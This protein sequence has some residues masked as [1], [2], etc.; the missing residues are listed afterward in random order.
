MTTESAKS[1]P[2]QT[3][4]LIVGDTKIE[5]PVVTG[6]EGEIAVDIRNLRKETGIITLDPGYGNTG[7]CKSS[8][9]FIDGEK[10][11]L[12]Y[13]GYAIEDLAGKSSVLDVAYLL[14]YGEL[15]TPDQCT[16]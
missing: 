8:I 7:A 11:I 5:L 1:R 3:A 10:G 4:T 14:L 9:T 13:R 12:R 15:P 2:I 6:A 16:S